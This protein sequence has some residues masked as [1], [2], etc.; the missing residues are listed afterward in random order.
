MPPLQLSNPKNQAIL[1]VDRESS[2]RTLDTL[3]DCFQKLRYEN[4]EFRR[5]IDALV[6]DRSSVASTR[7]RLM[8]KVN[9]SLEVT[10]ST[11]EQRY[12][13]STNSSMKQQ[14]LINERAVADLKKHQRRMGSE[15]QNKESVVVRL[16]RELENESLQRVHAE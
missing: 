5:V 14:L 9:K 4:G 11:D 1:I 2:D 15:I 13:M 6:T 16:S 12:L 10:A 3:E 7:D 8:A